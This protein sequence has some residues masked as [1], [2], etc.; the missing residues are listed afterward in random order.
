MGQPLSHGQ[1][2]ALARP[3]G[4]RLVRR[5]V[6]TSPPFSMSRVRQ[7]LPLDYSSSPFLDPSMPPPPRPLLECSLAVAGS[8]WIVGSVACDDRRGLGWPAGRTGLFVCCTSMAQKSHSPRG[9]CM[10]CRP[11]RGLSKPKPITMVCGGRG[12][13]RQYV[14][15]RRGS[16][17]VGLCLDR[18]ARTARFELARLL[19]RC[20]AI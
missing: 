5:P 6:S 10:P 8:R 9:H 3:V 12:R 4:V 14:C 2:A 19:G 17:P 13:R 15:P 1:P 20:A 11:I 18:P 7:V 16:M